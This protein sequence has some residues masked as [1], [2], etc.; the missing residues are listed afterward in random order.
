MWEAR[1]VAL[2]GLIVGLCVAAA[3]AITALLAGDFDDTHWRV[4]ATSLG[5]SLFSAFGASGDALR[6]QAGDWR[7][8]LGAATATLALAA[9]VL[10]VSA[11]WLGD[12]SGTLWRSF[13][14]AGLLALWG[15][16]AS[17]VVRAQR[18]DDAPLVDA[19]VWTSIATA[20]FDT[21]V[22]EV[23]I[24]GVVDDVSD[25]FVRLVAVAPVVIGLST[26]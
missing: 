25:A 16:H 26:G 3:T 19:L 23:A 14:V 6:R 12:G 15:S 2:R 8:T 11:I 7:A 10:L 4:I 17:L 1:S 21:L 13:G 18:R 24:L 20:T 9:F 5:F 22:G